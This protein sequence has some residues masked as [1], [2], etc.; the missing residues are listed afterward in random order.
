MPSP[1]A[2]RIAVATMNNKMSCEAIERGSV[3][4]ENIANTANR[5][6]ELGLKWVVYFRAQS[7]HHDINHV[8]VSFES[9]S[10]HMLCTEFE[11]FY[12][13]AHTITRS[14][15]ENGCTH[16]TCP[17]LSDDFHSVLLRQHNIN[18]QKIEFICARL[19]ETRLAVARDGDAKSGFAQSLR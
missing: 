7:A 17:E 3:R 2:S 1:L 14:Q 5:V 11:S 9:D 8:S 12:A 10:P 16:V 19:L 4:F 6:D 18:N 15:E 13:V